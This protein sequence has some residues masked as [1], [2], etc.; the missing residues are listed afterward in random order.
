[1]GSKKKNQRKSKKKSDDE[2]QLYDDDDDDERFQAASSRP[3]FAKPKEHSSKVVLDERFASVLT[4]PRFQLQQ[5]DKYGRRGKQSAAAA[6]NELSAFYTVERSEEE[7][8]RAREHQEQSGQEKRAEQSVDSSGKEEEEEE[9]DAEEPQDPAS[10]IAYLTAL[11]R[12]ELSASSSS[13]DDSASD[14]SDDSVDSDEEDPVYG[15]VGILDPSHKQEQ[16]EVSI[17]KESTKYMAV[18][19]M[20]WENVRAVDLFAIL[21]SFAPPGSVKRVQVFPSNFGIERMAQDALYGPTNLWKKKT[22]TEQSSARDDAS[23]DESSA[24]TEDE[25]DDNTRSSGDSDSEEE[26]S[27][28]QPMLNIENDYVESDFDMEKLRAYEAAKLK[29]YFAVVEFTSSEHADV[30]YQEVDGMEF[31][32][33]SAALDMRAIPEGDLDG[34]RKDRQLRDEVTALPGNYEPPEFIINALQQSS[35]K[36]TW[37][38]GDVD[39]ERKLTGY[40]RGDPGHWSSLTEADDLRAYLA[41][42]VSSDDDDEEPGSDDEKPRKGASMRKLLGLDSSEDDMEDKAQS[43]D[44][45]SSDDSEEQEGE[46]E[47]DENALSKQVTF[48]PGKSDLEGKI[49]SKLE[50]KKEGIEELTPWQKFQLKRKEKRRERRQARRKKRSDLE[51][52]EK[53]KPSDEGMYDSDPEFGEAEFEADDEGDDFFVEEGVSEKSKARDVQDKRKDRK[54]KGSTAPDGPSGAAPSTKEELELLLAGDD[55]EEDKKDYDMRGLQRIDKNKEKKLRGARKRKEAELV[56]NVS[57]AGFEIDTKD[58]RFAAVLDG[59]DDRFGIDPTDPNFKETVAMR[60]ILAEQTKRRKAKR[61]KHTEHE[62][63]VPN[64][65]AEAATTAS[66]GGAAALSS[67]VM[68]LKSKVAKRTQ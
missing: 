43:I 13:D 45:S 20:D 58:S 51:Q 55:D 54:A 63:V 35:V 56:A 57:G 14:S 66:S 65:S 62:K 67:L 11:S 16:D 19:N 33:S 39:R 17:T 26:Q 50:A 41:S 5:K 52:P 27:N 30:A 40:G 31:E 10:R 47:D 38:D 21:S 25:E 36:C 61:S 53:S 37:E 18:T 2:Q 44:E 49:R 48:V 15:S 7:K 60:Q 34:V 46:E 8:G 29:Y 22:Q 59:V 12:G 42:D 24:S 3:Q 28:Q 68:S 9:E 23:S 1:M 6:E 32:H 4:D 64:V